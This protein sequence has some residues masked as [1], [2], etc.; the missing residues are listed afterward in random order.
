[1]KK[2]FMCISVCISTQKGSVRFLGRALLLIIVCR[3]GGT[4]SRCSWF[5][6]AR[7][8][9]QMISTV[10]A[11]SAAFATVARVTS[12]GLAL[13]LTLSTLHERLVFELSKQ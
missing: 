11:L 9:Q 8:H 5:V 1:M 13:M 4:V 3:L 6:G 2:H 10:S 7:R 12:N